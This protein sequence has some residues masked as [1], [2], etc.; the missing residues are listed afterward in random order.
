[1]PLSLTWADATTEPR[2]TPKTGHKLF[3][4]VQVGSTVQL[5]AQKFPGGHHYIPSGDELGELASGRNDCFFLCYDVQDA[6]LAI[7]DVEYELAQE[8]LVIFLS[9]HLVTLREI[10]AL[11]HLQ[12]LKGL[13][14]LHGVLAPLI[15]R[16]F[17]ADL[18]RV[19]RFV[20]GL[21]IAVGQRPSWV[22]LLQA[23]D[24]IIKKLLV[25]G[26]V[27]WWVHHR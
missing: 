23:C 11:L 21:R 20:I 6:V 2:R 9:E 10:I 27:E 19:H 15:A 4:D 17:H 25:M 12:T 1:M 24:R 22:D 26:R 5:P 3:I 18:Q 7:L 16:F 14:E 8:R 13:D